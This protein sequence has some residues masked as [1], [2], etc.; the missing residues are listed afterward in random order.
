MESVTVYGLHLNF[1]FLSAK[2]GI[3]ETKEFKTLFQLSK[4]VGK[5]ERN[6]LVFVLNET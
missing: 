5:D 4:G 6:S 2:R 1:L 3:K